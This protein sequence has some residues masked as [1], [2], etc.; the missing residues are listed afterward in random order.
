LPLLSGYTRK[1]RVRKVYPYISGDILDL[2]C[3]VTE[4]LDMIP[5]VG[6]Y[7]GIDYNPLYFSW[8][9][10]KYPQHTFYSWNL[11]LDNLNLNKSFD[12]IIMAAILEH[13]KNPANVFQ[14]I[15]TLLKPSGKL[16]ITTPSPFGGFVHTIGSKIGL[17]HQDAADEHE[18]FYNFGHVVKL[19]KNFGLMLLHYEKFQFGA[20]QLFIFVKKK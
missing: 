6:S 12:T 5:T 9:K 13:L 7:V 19:L 17:F 18:V 20:N 2:G 14:K 11:D 4:L 10:N 1:A 8:L 3:G 16:I 15:N